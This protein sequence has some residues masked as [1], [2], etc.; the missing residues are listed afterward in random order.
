MSHHRKIGRGFVAPTPMVL[1]KTT[2]QLPTQWNQMRTSFGKRIFLGS[3]GPAR[4]F[5]K[6]RCFSRRSLATELSK[7]QSQAS[8][9]AKGARRSPAESINGLSIAW[10]EIRGRFSGKRSPSG[11]PSSRAPPQKT[12]M[13]RKRPVSMSI[14]FMS[15]S[16]IWGCIALIMAAEL[17]GMS[18]LSLKKPCETMVLPPRPY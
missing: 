15:C 14:E 5:G 10:T 12:P 4:S 8:T 9:M 3:D 18:P 13:P 11:H 6:T 16:E 2:P 7:N 17:F 1:H